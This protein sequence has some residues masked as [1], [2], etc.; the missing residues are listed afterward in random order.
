[1]HEKVQP[2]DDEEYLKNIIL[3]IVIKIKPINCKFLPTVIATVT[4]PN[5]SIISAYRNPE[6]T[7]RHSGCMYC[8]GGISPLKRDMS[9]ESAH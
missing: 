3:A 1:M 8:R 9:S 5:R 6:L 4:W 2:R 7:L